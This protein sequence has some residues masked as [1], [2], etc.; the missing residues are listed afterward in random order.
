M[1]RVSDDFSKPNCP[2][3]R[4]HFRK[5][6]VKSRQLRSKTVK[7]DCT[8][9]FTREEYEQIKTMAAKDFEDGTFK[10]HSLVPLAVIFMF[11]TGLRIGEVVGLKFSDLYESKLLV[12]RMIQYPD[13]EVIDDT[14]GEFGPRFVLLIPEA[15]ELI[16]KSV[17]SKKITESNATSFSLHRKSLYL[18]TGQYREHSENTAGK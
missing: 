5:I 16:E 14:K 12:Q 9:V 7:P 15:I 18:C 3:Y 10:V 13:G 2:I 6:K 17:N 8:Q 1:E 4:V 11:L